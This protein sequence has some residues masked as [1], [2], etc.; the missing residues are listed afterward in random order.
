MFSLIVSNHS[1]F[2]MRKHLLAFAVIFALVVGCRSIAADNAEVEVREEVLN[3]LVEH[4]GLISDSG[5]YQRWDDVGPE[6]IEICSPPMGSVD[7]P[8]IGP[9]V[10]LGADFPD[11]TP[12]SL[13]LIACKTYGGATMI[14]PVGAPIPWQWWVTDARFKVS[15][16]YMTFTATVRYQA[17]EVTGAETRS[18][19]AR[20]SYEQSSRK[21]V[22]LMDP[23]VKRI[24]Y[25]NSAGR[26]VTSVDVAELYKLTFELHP[27][28]MELPTLQGGTQSITGTVVSMETQYAPGIVKLL[29][30]L[31]F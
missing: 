27:Q 14:I 10:S 13:G 11:M 26:S 15:A 17:G 12:P 23:F 5:I 2:A 21:L 18:V 4:V 28:T 30:N 25:P 3:R 19:N 29:V 8:G 6:G 31:G 1:R 20:I 7:C 9:L 22:V 24:P 16:G